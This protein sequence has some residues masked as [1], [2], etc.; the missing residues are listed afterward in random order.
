MKHGYKAFYN[1]QTHE[2]YAENSYQA[3]LLAIEHFQPPRS[4]R[5]MV[6]VHLCERAD[7]SQVIHTPTE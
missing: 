1:N 2:V 6:H 4:K 3:Q 7:G 5:H